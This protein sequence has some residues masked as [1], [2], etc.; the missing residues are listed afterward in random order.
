[1]LLQEE[2]GVMAFDA[3]KI[4]LNENQIDRLQNCHVIADVSCYRERLPK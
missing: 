3:S 4:S 1:M 2:V